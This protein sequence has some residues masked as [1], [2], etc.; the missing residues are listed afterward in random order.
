MNLAAD[1]IVF[2]PTSRATDITSLVPL[3]AMGRR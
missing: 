1:T 2:V 3:K